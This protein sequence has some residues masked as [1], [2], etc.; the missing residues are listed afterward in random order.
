M[1]TRSSNSSSRHTSSRFNKPNTPLKTLTGRQLTSPTINLPSTSS[2]AASGF[3]QS[4]T[5]SHVLQRAQMRL[6]LRSS[7]GNC[8]IRTTIPRPRQG[9]SGYSRIRRTAL[10]LHIMR[11]VWSTTLTASWRRTGARCRMSIWTF[12][13]RA[14]TT[15]CERSWRLAPWAKLPMRLGLCQHRQAERPLHGLQRPPI[16]LL[17]PRTDP[18]RL[19]RTGSVR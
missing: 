14:R 7:I 15:S 11:I 2:R 9:T 12:Y 19:P 18:S 8:S 5:R 6:S 16:D 1:P 13:S 3:L 10:Q 17:R 4:L